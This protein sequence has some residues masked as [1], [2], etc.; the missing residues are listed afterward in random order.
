MN[1]FRLTSLLSA[2]VVGGLG[3]SAFADTYVR[4]FEDLPYGKITDQYPG[5]T[6]STLADGGVRVEGWELSDFG[7][8]VV[9]APWF[10][11]IYGPK[12]MTLTVEF[13]PPVNKLSFHAVSALAGSFSLGVEHAGGYSSQT[14]SV[15]VGT[16]KIG[17][18]SYKNVVRIELVQ[19]NAEAW[20]SWDQFTYDQEFAYSHPYGAGSGGLYGVPYLSAATPPVVGTNVVLK[21]NNVSPWANF[22]LLFVGDAPAAIPYSGGTLLVEPGSV[23][24]V[25]MSYGG[26]GVWPIAS[27]QAL[28]GQSMFAQMMFPDYTAWSGYAFTPGLRLHFGY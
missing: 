27:D 18:E 17:L 22:G 9:T 28:A 13:D 21:W 15:S 12:F 19:H 2:I 3:A 7:P 11:D 1:H 25:P 14:P 24:P 23:L 4:D 6:F 26:S 8:K 16:T 20:Y 5:V 10:G